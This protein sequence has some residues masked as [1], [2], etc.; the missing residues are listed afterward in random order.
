MIGESY[1]E[2]THSLLIELLAA[3]AHESAEKT[4]RVYLSMFGY[5]KHGFNLV[6]L[7]VCLHLDK[8]ELGV[9]CG[10]TMVI[11]II[12]TLWFHC[13]VAGDSLFCR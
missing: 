11:N 12:S 13:L 8:L 2:Y 5:R 7:P 4:Q 10:S 3:L 1:L 6:V 9:I